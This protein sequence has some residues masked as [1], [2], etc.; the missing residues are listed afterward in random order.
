MELLSVLIQAL[1]G[2]SIMVLTLII[3]IAIFMASIYMVGYFSKSQLRHV[4]R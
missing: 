1:A 2:I 4:Y 3:F